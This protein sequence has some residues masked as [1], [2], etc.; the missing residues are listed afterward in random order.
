M[1][2]V[3]KIKPIILFAFS[4]AENPNPRP[5]TF[6]TIFH[7]PLNGSKSLLKMGKREHEKFTILDTIGIKK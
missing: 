3:P 2:S 7:F 1:M 6:F 4:L 5:K